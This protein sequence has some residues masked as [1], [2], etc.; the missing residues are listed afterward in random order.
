MRSLT[1][2]GSGLCLALLVA[3]V[4]ARAALTAAEL[5]LDEAVLNQFNAVAFGDDTTR[6]ETEGRIAVGGSFYG[7]GGD[8]CFNGCA[9]NT[10]SVAGATYG[11][12]TVW[13][14]VGGTGATS[15]ANGADFYIKGNNSAGS[16]L[17][18]NYNGGV[19]ISG[20]NSGTITAA[21]FVNTGAASAGTTQNLRGGTPVN[22]S[23]PAATTFPLPASM[24][25]QGALADLASSIADDAQAVTAQ[26]LGANGN[27]TVITATAAS[28]NYGGQHYG[29]I[30][31]TMADLAS[32]QNF[33]GI[34]TNG[35]NAV[36]VVVTGTSS[37]ALPNLNGNFNETNVIWDFTDA[38]TV[39]FAGNWYGQ[40]LAPAATV[41]NPSGELAGSI[42]ANAINQFNEFHQYS[43]GGY[44]LPAGALNGLPTAAVSTS[45]SSGTAVDEP[46]TIAVLLVG[47]LGLA[48]LRRKPARG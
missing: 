30:T 16:T 13:G 32:Q 38:T 12:L 10:T 45:Q 19:N 3:I 1:A 11:A 33:G 14:N 2:V 26:T 37:A 35:L 34:N 25:F 7:S 17:N 31:T 47:T 46:S 29:F 27:N 21:S 8:I 42:I 48:L 40:I 6:S 9:G 36:F 23:Q 24:P 28:G 41:S 15:A 18:M 44:V 20:S 4:P 5:S 39:N 43:N 22:T